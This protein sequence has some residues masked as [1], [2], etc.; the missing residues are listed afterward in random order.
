MTAK[1]LGNSGFGLDP[2]RLAIADAGIV[3]YGVEATELVDLVGNGPGPGD[4][5]E[6]ASHGPLGAGRGRKG[7]AAPTVVSPVQDDLM[8]LLDQEPRRQETKAVR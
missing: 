7:V 6:V 5:R 2:P 3:D 4:G 1:T 8:A